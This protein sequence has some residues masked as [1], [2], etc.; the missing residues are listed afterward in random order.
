MPPLKGFG[1]NIIA[2]PH[3]RYKVIAPYGLSIDN[4]PYACD[5]EL[6]KDCPLRRMPERLRQLVDQRKLELILN[7]EQ[8]VKP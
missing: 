3:A 8:E 1:S 7:G 5:D 6:E 2:P 4:W